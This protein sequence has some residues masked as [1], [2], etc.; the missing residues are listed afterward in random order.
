MLQMIADVERPDEEPVEQGR[1]NGAGAVEFVVVGK[2][3]MF[4]HGADA[5]EDIDPEKL[6]D[7][8]EAQYLDRKS[9]V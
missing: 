4:G 3:V 9:V 6:R 2:A 8:N 1:D 7:E 5:I